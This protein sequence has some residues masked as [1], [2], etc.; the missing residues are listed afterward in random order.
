MSR[1]DEA[2]LSVAASMLARP[3]RARY[4]EQWLADLR[5]AQEVG[6]PRAAVVRG[7]IGFALIAVP[8]EV[9]VAELRASIG[10]VPITAATLAV[11]LPLTEILF[12]HQYLTGGTLTNSNAG[13]LASAVDGVVPLLFPVLLV[14]VGCFRLFRE[15]GDR[16]VVNTRTRVRVESYVYAKL[17]VAVSIAFVVFFAATFVAFTVSFVVWPAIGNPGVDTTGTLI[18]GRPW[19]ASDAIHEYTFTQLL[20]AGPMPF[21]IF[22]SVW[23]G[24]GAAT[25][26]ALGMAGLL[27]VRRPA[28]GLAVP[29]LFVIGQHATVI[30]LGQDRLSVL[31]SIFPFGY[32]Q[33]PVIV[34]LAPLLTLM[35]LVAGL[36]VVLLRRV[37]RLDALS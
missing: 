23:V 28:I 27:I 26:T 5:D 37:A 18:D 6:L 1:M 34:G 20:A 11:L 9:V 36:W 29:L 21:G 2:L 32:V 7:A 16:F 30:L 19:Q 33:A 17:L 25:L 14:L 12:R 15:L 31:N 3:V 22:Y 10:W 4:H 8:R 13:I 24:L 35:V